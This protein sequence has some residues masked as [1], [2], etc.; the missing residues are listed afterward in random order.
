MIF[1][2]FVEVRM[3]LLGLTWKVLPDYRFDTEFVEIGTRLIGP[4]IVQVRDLQ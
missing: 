4:S 1:V 3:V 2:S